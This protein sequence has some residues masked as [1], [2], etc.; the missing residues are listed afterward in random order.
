MKIDIEPDF[1]GIP[2]TGINLEKSRLLENEAK[3]LLSNFYKLDRESQLIMSAV[4]TEMT[5]KR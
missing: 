2:C 1:L 4:M 5:T 3:L